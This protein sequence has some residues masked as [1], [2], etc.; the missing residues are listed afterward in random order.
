MKRRNVFIGVMVLLLTLVGVGLTVADGPVEGRPG[1]AEVR[2]L[3]GMID[4][5]QMAL[6]MAND[7]L[8]K[9]PPCRA[10]YR[11]GTTSSMHRFP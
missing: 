10:G 6:D 11:L 9:L 8:M 2:F 3:E 5:H 4:H 1:R 7:C